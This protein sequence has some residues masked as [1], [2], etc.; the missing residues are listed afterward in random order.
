M[1]VLRAYE[2]LDLL[3]KVLERF[4]KERAVLKG[5]YLELFNTPEGELVSDKL[6]NKIEAY[7][8]TDVHSFVQYYQNLEEVIHKTK[9]NIEYLKGYISG[10]VLDLNSEL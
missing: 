4:Y 5:D 9:V 7:G 8:Y 10:H 2:K 6:R 3:E 1:G